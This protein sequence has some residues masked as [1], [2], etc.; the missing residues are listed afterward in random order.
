[1]P[2]PTITQV[3]YRIRDWQSRF[4]NNRTRELK[5]LE[6]VKFP[7]PMLDGGGDTYADLMN[8][9]NGAAHFGFWVACVFLASRSQVRGTLLR[10]SGAPHCRSS[11]ALTCR[12]PAPLCEEAA[13]RLVELGWLEELP[14]TKQTTYE[15]AGK[16][17]HP[18]GIPHEPATI[19][20]EPAASRARANGTVQEKIPPVVPPTGGTPSES[21]GT[22]YRGRRMV[23]R[24]AELAQEIYRDA[25]KR[26]QEKTKHDSS[27][28]TDS[29]N[30]GH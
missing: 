28:Q 27:Q 19:P 13:G 5:Y 16:S 14:Y 18:A 17:P 29:A 2:E 20:Q 3:V 24:T 25:K 26:E 12:I 15:H 22:R 30:R 7:N 21:N 10:D 11:I 1:M 4:E 8:H 9:P 6:W 23:S